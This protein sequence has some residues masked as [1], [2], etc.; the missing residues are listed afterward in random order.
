KRGATIVAYLA[1]EGQQ[2]R[3]ALGEDLVDV[4]FKSK[5]VLDIRKE[6]T[7]EVNGF[8]YKL[9]RPVEPTV[10]DGIYYYTAQFEALWYDLIDVQFRG[11]DANN[12]LTLSEFSIYATA[13]DIVDLVVRNANRLQS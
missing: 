9:N 6:D 10:K 12:E 5:T 3:K 11:L 13:Y 1:L 8:T 4:S 7:V 2:I